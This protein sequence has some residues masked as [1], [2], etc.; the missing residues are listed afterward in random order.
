MPKAVVA[1]NNFAK[2]KVDH[3]LMARFDLPLYPTSADVMRN[4]FTNFKGNAIYRTGLQDMVGEFEDCVFQ[5]FL[6]RN[7]QNYIMVFYGTTIRFLTYASDG[8]FGW[9]LDSGGPAI[10]E[11]TTPYSLDECRDLQFAQNG[12]VVIITHPDY[13]PRELTRTGAAAFSIATKTFTTTNPFTAPNWPACCAFYKGRLYFASTPNEITT[14]WASEAGDFNNF[15]IP[16]TVTDISPLKFTLSEITQPIEWLFGGENSL[17]GGC[18]QGLVAINGGGVGSAIKA[19]TI[20][21]DLTATDGSNSTIPLTKDGKIFYQGKNSR[22]VYYF[23]YDLLTESFQAED[24][25]F[26]SYDI[27]RGDLGKIRDKKDRNDLIYVVKDNGKFLSLNFKEKENIAGWHEHDTQGLV[28][29][30]AVIS[31]NEGNPQLFALVDRDGGFFIE[32]MAPHIEFSERSSF[33]SWNMIENQKVAENRDDDAYNRMV[34]EELRGCIYLDSS[35]KFSDLKEDNLITYDS[36]AG[37]ITDTDG[38]F[39]SGDVGKHISYKTAT[40]YEY[41]RFEI[42]GYTDANTVDVNVLVEP[43]QNTYENWY[44]SFSQISGLTQY[45]GKTIGVVTDGGFLDTFDI[46]GDT[47]D[48]ENQ[49]LSV[50]VGYTYRGEIKSFSLGFQVKAENTQITMK[51]ITQS[52]IRCVSTAGLKF[53]SSPYKV[54]PVQQLS[55]DDLNYL[56]PLP[57]DGTKT[58]DYIDE[59]QKDKYFYIIQDLPLPAIVAGVFL[60]ANYTLRQ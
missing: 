21:A 41:G 29:D 35:L 7:D 3:D 57:I 59:N 36:G 28:K 45:I 24:A 9:V 1:Y 2:G 22:N 44:L 56:P 19:D 60:N 50:V 12:D 32:R 54:E 31:D 49:V 48:F 42:T 27:T 5:E 10:L 14:V 18:A 34:A 51:S 23:S 58:V 53:G 15:V 38:V 30:I 37:T 52:E 39:V 4:F 11:V 13:A 55:Q 26:L 47:L 6:F 40:G 25:N 16:G 17:I 20:E 43:S 33:F 8:T 46:T